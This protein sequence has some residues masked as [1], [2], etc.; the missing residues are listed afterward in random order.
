MKFSKIFTRQQV[1]K[2]RPI[3]PT[4]IFRLNVALPEERHIQEICELVAVQGWRIT[5]KKYGLAYSTEFNM[6][7]AEMTSYHNVCV[8]TMKF[9]S[10]FTIDRIEC[11]YEP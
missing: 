1:G 6:A 11:F 2:S 7:V 10:T 3:Q 9:S 8:V 5:I 4:E